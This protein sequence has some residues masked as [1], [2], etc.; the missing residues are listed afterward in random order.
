MNLQIERAYAE[1]MVTEFPD[2]SLLSEQLKFGNRAEVPFHRLTSQQLGYL[3][4]L[5]EGAGPGMAGLAAQ[6]ANLEQAVNDP[7]ERYTEDDLERLVPDIV[8]FLLK[9]AIRGWI[10]KA[11]ATGRPAPYLVS[12]IDFTPPGEEEA[13]RILIDLKANAM[14]KVQ[15]INFI[16]RT[17]DIIGKSIP[18]IFA[19]KGFLKETEALIAAYDRSAELFFEWRS[20][21][22]RQF[23]ARG[24][25]VFAEDPTASHR[26]TDWSRK[27]RVVL[28]SG[29]GWAR[30]VNDEGI[31]KERALSL[32]VAGDILG[33]Y[34][35]RAGR[36][37]RYDEN[38]ED[39]TEVL[40]DGI[41]KKLFTELPVHGYILLFHLD[42][43]HH[44]W[45]HVDDMKPYCYQP[46]L[47]EKLILP[48]EQTDLIDI[49]TA[50]MDLL[51]DDIVEGKSGGTTVLCAGPPGV[52]KTL[53]AE[54]YS[55]IIR[56]P[57]YRVHS[58]QL[59]LNVTEMERALKETLTRAQRWGAVMLID[60]ADVYIKRRDDN[61]AANAVVGVFLRVLEYFNGLL[62]L[63]TN[64]VDD[65]DEAIVSRCIALIKYHPPELQDRRKIWRVMVEQFG[66]DVSDELIDKLAKIYP[67]ASGR[68]I[69]GLTKLVAKYCHH[70]SLTPD[71]DVFN[72]CC[73]FRGMEPEVIQP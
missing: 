17:R 8:E 34:L 7:G 19:A 29:G 5:Y 27:N 24:T 21:D 42:L 48:P 32:E 11:D 45:V 46:E 37:T 72:R 38:V 50:E 30:L 18:E 60:E 20:E 62:F 39:A 52:G 66:L 13:G 10:F 36:S 64:R 35:R 12:R 14:A 15:T 57:L 4:N 65:I 43:H 49:L 26:N 16:I 22:G 25:G 73:I 70:K 40:R 9:G 59:G 51:M 67:E 69:K 33:K 63:T 23:N 44:L 53:T 61:I 28:S 31:L 55:E 54:V 2:L 1:L 71:L 6:L 56:R 47:K 58:G 41:P 3:R 68:D